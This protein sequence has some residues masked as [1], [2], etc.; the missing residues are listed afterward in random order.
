[1]QKR[2]IWSELLAT[3]RQE[4]PPGCA[5]VAPVAERGA[6]ILIVLKLLRNGDEVPHAPWVG[7]ISAQL[8]V[9]SDL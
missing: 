5:S 3:D 8:S 4:P 1:M 7:D 6:T 9:P 2:E